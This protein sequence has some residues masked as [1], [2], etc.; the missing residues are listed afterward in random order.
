M[1]EKMKDYRLVRDVPRVSFD[2]KVK[3]WIVKAMKPKKY[4]ITGERVYS[5]DNVHIV[6]MV[7]K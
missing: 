4:K 5:Q 2:P 3:E 7:V 6:K 1:E